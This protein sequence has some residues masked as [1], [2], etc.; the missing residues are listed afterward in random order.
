MI[1]HYSCEE[2]ASVTKAKRRQTTVTKMFFPSSL[3][4]NGFRKDSFGEILSQSRHSWRDPL[5]RLRYK[6][7]D[8]AP[9][10]AALGIIKPKCGQ[11]GP[12][13]YDLK[14]TGFKFDNL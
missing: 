6:I 8:R 10:R 3:H 12:F 13:R 11:I 5:R 1:I 14:Y 4:T 2:L 7:A 9:C